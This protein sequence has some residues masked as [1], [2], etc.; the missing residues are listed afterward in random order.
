MQTKS[1][2]REE[3]GSGEAPQENFPCA[4]AGDCQSCKDSNPDS[5]FIPGSESNETGLQN[6]DRR[7][8]GSQSGQFVGVT[9]KLDRR[10]TTV[11]IINDTP[12]NVL[13]DTGADTSVLTTAHYSKLKY[14][15]KRYQGTGILG[16]GGNVETFST[17]VTIKKKGKQIKTRM[18]VADIPVTIIGRDILQELGAQLVMAQLSTEISPRRIKLKPGMTGPKIPQWPLTKEKLTGAKEIIQRLLSEGKISEA[19]DDNPFNSPIFVIKKRSG[20]WRLLQDLRELNKAVQVGTEISRGLPHPG[21]LIKSKNMTVMDIG[22]A[23][24]TIP[25][26]PLFRRY[27]AFTVPSINHQEPDKR[28][29]WNCLPQG[30]ILSPYIYQKTLQEILQPFRDRHPEVQLYQYMDDLFIGSNESRKQHNELVK[31]LR[32][33]LL[34][35]GFETPEEK[36]QDEAPYGWLGYQLF[37]NNWKMPTVQ[38]ELAKEPTLNDV[39]KLMGNI[40]WISSGIPGLT[41]KHIAATTKGCL[42]LNEKV[43][44]TAEAQQEL[45]QNNEKVQKAQGLQYYNPDEEVICE[46]NLTKN[47]EATYIVKQSQGILWAG[48]KIMKANKGRSTVKNLMLLLQHVATESITRIGICPTFKVPFTKEQVSWEM[49]KGWYYSWLPEIIYSSQVVHDEWKLK[50]VEEPTSGITIYTDGGKQNGRGV[51]AYVTSTG[52]TKQKQLGPVTHQRAEM[53]AIQMALE[54]YN[55]KQLNIVTDSYYCWKNITEGLGLEGPDSPWWPIIQ[56]IYNKETIYFAWVPGHKGIYGNQLADEATKITEEIMLAYQGTQIRNKRKEDA[57]FDLCSPYDITLHV[58][59]T[60]IIPTDVKIQVPPQC[61]GWVTGKS[62]MAKQG[63]LVNGGIIDEGYTGEIQVICTNIGQGIVKLLEGQKFA[64]LII[65]Q[66][67]SNDTHQWDENKKS[68]RG[69]HGFGS[70]GIFWVDNIQDAQDEHENWHTSPKILAKKYGLPLTVAK[71]ITQECPH[72]TKQGSGPA[73]CVMRSPNHWQADCTRLENKIIM[74]FVDSNSGYIHATLLPKE[75]ALHTS[76]A[77]LEWVRIFSPK[78]LHTDNGTNFTAES[79]QNLLKFLKVTHTTGIPY[80][81]ESQGI[82]ERANRTLKEKIQSHRENTQ[83]LEAA[84]QLALITCNK[85]RESM[86]GQTPWEVFVTNQAQTIHEELLLQQ[87]QSSKKFCFYKVPGEHNWK[88]PTRVLWKGDGAVVVND[89]EKG[90]IAIPLTRTKLLIKP[91]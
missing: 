70:T 20:K 27:T 39:Q 79:V 18:L 38:L 36:L 24:F 3:W 61:F 13:L 69:E 21:G 33:I 87:A 53:I 73:G 10:P 52:K 44:W 71:Q 80:H 8:R 65:L 34:E 51:A 7:G 88:G 15:G 76:L 4:S 91:N 19:S 9:Y 26:D 12:L 77:I 55:D 63:L 66:H 6:K 72:C 35:K 90:I 57:G 48:K 45:E 29:V 16:V 54:D 28:Y 83:T 84:L 62:S 37:P 82:I 89:E 1:K 31:E 30:F 81:P 85:G 56:N 49:K 41:V 64:Q 58:S 86:G 17:P 47:C 60:K 59:E 68:E 50:L 2:K 32:M 46:I 22:D 11:V 42:D 43:N 23:Y 14:R 5:E 78:S 67:Q 25:L 75:N 74:T 40:T